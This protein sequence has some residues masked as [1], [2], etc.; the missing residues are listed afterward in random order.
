MA[1]SKARDIDEELGLEYVDEERGWELIEE[2]AQYYLVMSGVEFVE[3]YRKGLIPDP[4]SSEVLSVA[5]LLP[6]IGESSI[7]GTHPG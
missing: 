3:R 1:V 7:G 2:A 4:Y 5:L 6:F